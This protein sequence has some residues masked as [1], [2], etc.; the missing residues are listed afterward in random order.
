[1][2]TK[3]TDWIGRAGG[4]LTKG[5]PYTSLFL[6]PGGSLAVIAV[7]LAGLTRAITG[8]RP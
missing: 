5:L 4:A 8:V 6:L 2:K 3:M 1:M 7:L